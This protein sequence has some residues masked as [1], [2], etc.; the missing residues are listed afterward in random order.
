MADTPFD[1]TGAV[2][3]D[4]S[5][6]RVSLEHASERVLAP[7][8]GLA[9][10]CK[11]AGQSATQEFGR[12]I[13][14]AMGQRLAKRVAPNPEDIRSVTME[15][16]V[17]HLRGEFA[18][19]GLGVIHMELWGSALLFVVNHDGVPA[20]L[21]ASVLD[22]AIEAS[23]GRATACVKVEES[24]GASRYLVT[25]RA[26]SERVSGWVAAGV[27]WSEALVRLHLP[28]GVKSGGEA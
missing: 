26:T 11:A 14:S 18:L 4:L 24:L 20:Y 27:P 10:L 21:V 23:T 8:D 17:E 13:G 22:A 7:V 25:N 1:P 15:L 5:S 28:T 12:A 16:F 3:F 19:A 2:T 9:Q 6:G